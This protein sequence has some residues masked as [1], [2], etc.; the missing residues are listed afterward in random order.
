MHFC[1]IESANNFSF[2]NNLFYLNKEWCFLMAVNS[3]VFISPGAQYSQGENKDNISKETSNTTSTLNPYFVTGFA[4]GEGCFA[5][6]I[7]KST[8][9][10]G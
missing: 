3:L 7:Y 5:I 10:I 9:T 2:L 1:F 4:D 6:N 8:T